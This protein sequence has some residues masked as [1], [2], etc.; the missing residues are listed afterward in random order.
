MAGE[1]VGVVLAALVANGAIAV[2]KFGGFLLTGSPAMLAETYHS[3]SDT[4]NQVFLLVGIYYGRQERDR[5]HPFGYG[6]AEFFYSFLVSVLLFGIAGW[7]SA[8]GGYEALVHGEAHL[9]EGSVTL[10]GTTVPGIYVN[11]AVLLGAI[12]FET[13][14]L[15]KARAAM[16]AEID[17]RGWSGYREAFKK[18][19]RT[20]VL[21]ALTED[22][23]A[24]AGL[25]IALAGIYLTR[26]TGNPV[27]DGT[28]ALLIGLMLMGFALA[29]A[30]EN[31]RLLIGESLPKTDERGLREIVA[32]WNGVTEITG[33]RSVHFGPD[34]LLVA[35]DV[36]FDPALDGEEIDERIG[37][38]ER[39]LREAD[40]SVKSV[41]IEPQTA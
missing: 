38:I 7:E 17:E 33:F 5:S 22:T 39:A 12:V 6:K 15:I 14:A 31:K 4:G 24:L 9:T 29:L 32:G 41:Y 1:S 27:Y 16:R 10:L 2:L 13:Y 19:S 30:W 3:V 23:V 20:T 11:Y 34:Y 21:T 26:V 8:K 37:G 28:A 36:G 25:G 35:A 40:E 18:T